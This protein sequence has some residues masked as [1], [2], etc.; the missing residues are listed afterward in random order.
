MRESVFM[1]HISHPD[2]NQSNE[3]KKEI[4][5]SIMQNEYIKTWPDIMKGKKILYVHGFASSGQS[6]TVTL[7]RTL[8]PS[9]TVIAPDN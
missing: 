5:S 3:I 9:A 6:G 8:L 2:R 1:Y 4:H 7:L